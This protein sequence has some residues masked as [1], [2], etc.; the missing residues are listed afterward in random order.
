MAEE[1]ELRWRTLDEVTSAART[2]LDPVLGGTRARLW[3]PDLW[4]WA[5]R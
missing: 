4:T 1:D 2:F 5:S 3:R